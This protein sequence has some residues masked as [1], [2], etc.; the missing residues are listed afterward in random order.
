MIGLQVRTA[1]SDLQA[2]ATLEGHYSLLRNVLEACEHLLESLGSLVSDGS[3][4]TIRFHWG[5]LEMVESLLDLQPASWALYLVE[6][7]K[8]AP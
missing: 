3:R 4:N 5:H 6:P 1:C 2:K 7:N 8:G